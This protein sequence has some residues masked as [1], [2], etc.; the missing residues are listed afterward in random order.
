MFFFQIWTFMNIHIPLT[1]IFA[2]KFLPKVPTDLVCNHDNLASCSRP[3]LLYSLVHR[4]LHGCFLASAQTFANVH[5]CPL[6]IFQHLSRGKGNFWFILHSA[7]KDATLSSLIHR[8]KRGTFAESMCFLPNPPA[9]K[10]KLNHNHNLATNSADPPF[11]TPPKEAQG[12]R[13]V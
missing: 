5:W 6:N 13:R 1:Q 7:E 11:L 9:R 8:E 12:Q 4:F 2:S 10:Y 3:G